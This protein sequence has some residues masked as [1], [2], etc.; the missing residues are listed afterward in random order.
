MKAAG[1]RSRMFWTRAETQRYSAPTSHCVGVHIFTCATKRANAPPPP[2]PTPPTLAATFL[3]KLG[4]IAA[5]PPA[6]SWLVS[7]PRITT[8]LIERLCDGSI[9]VAPIGVDDT[10]AHWRPAVTGQEW[11]DRFVTPVQRIVIKVSC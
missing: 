7:R 1:S 10:C 2:P 11:E 3:L 9:D 4:D 8:C 6:A 5:V